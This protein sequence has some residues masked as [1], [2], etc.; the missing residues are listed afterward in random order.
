[1]KNLIKT[2]AIVI[3]LISGVTAVMAGYFVLDYNK[4]VTEGDGDPANTIEFA[5]EEGETVE[6][7]IMEEDV[8]EQE[9]EIKE[10]V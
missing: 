7:V 9:E 1:M 4:A 3:L 8:V 2:I 10:I 5:I 6:E